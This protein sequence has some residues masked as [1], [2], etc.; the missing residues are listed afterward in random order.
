MRAERG[1]LYYLAVLR[2]NLDRLN[3]TIKDLDLDEES[4]DALTDYYI[5]ADEALSRAADDV[6]R[7]CGT[8]AIFAAILDLQ[9]LIKNEEHIYGD[10]I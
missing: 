8:D 4:K 2:I 7:T 5:K 3:S 9:D 6:T 1:I 10:N